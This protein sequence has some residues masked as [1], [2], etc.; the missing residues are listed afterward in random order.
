VVR[1]TENNVKVTKVLAGTYFSIYGNP[2]SS[3]LISFPLIINFHF[4][5]SCLRTSCPNAVLFLRISCQYKREWKNDMYCAYERLPRDEETFITKGSYQ[6]YSRSAV[7]ITP[8]LF[9]TVKIHYLPCLQQPVACSCPQPDEAP[10][11]QTFSIAFLY[12]SFESLLTYAP[13][14]RTISVYLPQFCKPF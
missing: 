12:T 7:H 13:D 2:I 9:V 14:C 11:P 10:H 4:L 8:Y 3:V 6:S 5:P 1:Y